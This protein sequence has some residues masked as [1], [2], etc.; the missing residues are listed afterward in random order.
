MIK[1]K[2]PF[3]A[4]TYLLLFGLLLSLVLSLLALLAFLGF[5]G[6]LFSLDLLYIGDVHL[7]VV[8][9]R[10]RLAMLLVHLLKHCLLLF[11]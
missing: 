5:V 9:L 7:A 8:F 2:G 3:R 1:K 11:V 6:F 10:L 4:L